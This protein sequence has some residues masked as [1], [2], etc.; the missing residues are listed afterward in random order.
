MTL[1]IFRKSPNLEFCK[2][3]LYTE[4]EGYECLETGY[5]DLLLNLSSYQLPTVD[6]IFIVN[7]KNIESHLNL[8][9]ICLYWNYR[10]K[11]CSRRVLG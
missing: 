1:L 10:P 5:Y 9:P 4:K 7:R 6:G 2:L 3:P 8:S 11:G